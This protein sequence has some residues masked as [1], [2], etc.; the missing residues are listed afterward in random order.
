V[1]SRKR[2]G[3]ACVTIAIVTLCGVASAFAQVRWFDVPSDDAGKSIPQFASQAHVQVLAPGAELHGVITPP[4]KGVYDT[5]VALNL[6]LK[7]TGLKASHWAEG[8]VTISR[9]DSKRREKDEEEMSPKNST[10][11]LALILGV[12]AGNSANAQS[13]PADVPPAPSGAAAA[14]VES[15]TVSGTGSLIRGINP[16]GS[17]LVS[18]DADAMKAAGALTSNQILEQVPQLSNAFNTNAAAPTA[19]NFSGF[20]PQIRSIPSQ[21]IVGG[22]ATLL[23]LDGQ[24]MVGVS[25][26]GTAPDASMIPTV[27]LRRVDVLPDGASA[28][29]GANAL[30]GVINFITRDTFDGL[31]L[32]ADAGF[33]DGYTSFNASAMGGTTWEGGGAYIAIQ[34]Q[35]NTVLMGSDRSYTKMDLTGIG[36]RDSRATAC[37]LPNISV[38]SKNY[39]EKAYPA[40]SPGSL[41]ASVSGPFGPVD[42]VTNAGSINRCDTNADTSIFPSTNMTG[43]FGSFRQKIAEGIEF[44]TKMVWNT[45]F[46]FARMPVAATTQT[47][48]NS[49]PYFQSLGGETSQ[50]VQFS[51]APFLGTNQTT[52]NNSVQ[53]FQVTPQ[54]NVSLPFKDWE[55]TFTGNYGRSSTNTY[56]DKGLDTALL[57]TALKT[58]IGGKYIDPYNIALSDQTLANETLSFKSGGTAIQKILQ[59][60][61][62][63]DGTAFDL[64]GGPVKVA[65]GGKYSWESF[66]S[67]LNVGITP[68]TPYYGSHRVVESGFSEVDVPL[69]GADNRFPLVYSLEFD[70]SGRIDDYSVFG[71]TSNFKLGLSYRPFEELT[72]RAT[73]GT[74]YDAPSLADTTPNQGRY[75]Y[76]VHTTPNPIVPPGT[77]LA[78]SL[79]PSILTPGANENLRP[80]LG[81]TWSLGADF[82]PTQYFGM[83]FSGLD[84]SVTAYH[85]TIEHQ[86]GLLVNNLQLFQVPSYANLYI[87]NPTLQQVAAYGKTLVGGFPGPDLAS[88]FAPGVT[89]P[90]IMYDARR[91]NLGN[92]IL[93]GIDF[94][95]SY[96]SDLDIGT[97]SI[98]LSGTVSTENKTAGSAA[99]PFVSIQSVG[100]PLYQLAGYAQL[101]TGPWYLRTS[102]Q[103]TPSFRVDPTTQAFSL[104]HQQRIGSFATVNAHVGYDLSGLTSW[105]KNTELGLTVNNLFDT[106]PPIYLHGGPDLP[107]NSGVGIV[108]SGSTLGRYFLVSLQKTL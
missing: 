37:A 79:R 14:N 40:S 93:S 43:L 54:L 3:L 61:V 70:A 10:S 81:S 26:L 71:S 33:A 36:G 12:F 42:P 77:S 60:Q 76:A 56:D 104:Y 25:G 64:P 84:L 72:L 90:Y 69:V 89:P 108:A 4:V 51:Y 8:I 57:N 20:R 30:T 97:L 24:N 102:L 82:K 91:N 50:T 98:G 68:T 49:N 58:G 11:I 96:I 67:T 85:L 39:A 66:Y 38:G 32:S 94:S 1:R 107:A 41:A 62:G 19:Q 46:Q 23:L 87:L 13:A 5:F 65:I 15:V 92:S 29:Y 74:S 18:V 59:S 106:D 75:Q 45:R 53:V 86:I 73:R 105:S 101:V 2:C 44:S 6:M 35:E 83:D 7:G 80:E 88:A 16:V 31:Q 9:L 63:V 100:V 34:H 21:N 103:Y 22:S 52:S 95:G 78:D 27:V 28:T 47:I 17:N 48:T 55:L 99:G